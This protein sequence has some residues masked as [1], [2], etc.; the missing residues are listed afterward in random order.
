MRRGATR[1][2]ASG[3]PSPLS[4][5]LLGPV[6]TFPS[7]PSGFSGPG[8]N[9]SAQPDPASGEF[10]YGLREVWMVPDQLMHPLTRH[11]K[12]LPDLSDAHEIQLLD[13]GASLP[14]T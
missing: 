3:S 13:H 5:K 4:N 2:Q 7:A 1:G 10:R 9:V 11:P 14:L 8:L 6:L 12:D